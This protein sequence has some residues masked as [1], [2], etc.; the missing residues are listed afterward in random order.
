MMI[1][2]MMPFH[3]NEAAKS[4]VFP[5][6]GSRDADRV[7]P[8]KTDGAL[9]TPASKRIKLDQGNGGGQLD[10][11]GVSVIGSEGKTIRSSLSR[12]LDSGSARSLAEMKG[13]RSSLRTNCSTVH[14]IS[15]LLSCS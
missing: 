11:G 1:E 7:D 10:L 5:P 4:A 3:E 2:T 14:I 8:T 15:H 9:E 6:E 12:S 13:T